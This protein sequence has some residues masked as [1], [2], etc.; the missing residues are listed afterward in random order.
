MEGRNVRKI[1]ESHVAGVNFVLQA[2][3]VQLNPM[4]SG[5]DV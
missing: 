4:N 3:E 1:G 2:E 5:A